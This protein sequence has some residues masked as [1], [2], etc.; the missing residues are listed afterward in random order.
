MFNFLL[1]SATTLLAWSNLDLAVDQ[2]INSAP[3]NWSTMTYGILGVVGYS[4]FRGYG[5]AKTGV[6][7]LTVPNHIGDRAGAL[8]SRLAFPT[9]VGLTSYAAAATAASDAAL[10][11]GIMMG[12]YSLSAILLINA[13]RSYSYVHTD[14]NLVNK[15]RQRVDEAKSGFLTDKAAI[16][17]ISDLLS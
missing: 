10:S 12:G 7:K 5:L 11:G 4:L 17:R 9:A 3:A 14:E 16:S 13:L 8:A 2:V 1:L 6:S 15:V